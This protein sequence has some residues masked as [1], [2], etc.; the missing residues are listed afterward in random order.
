MSETVVLAYSGGLDTSVAVRWLAENRGFEVVTLTVDLGSQPNLQL[1]E[2]KALAS[3]ARRAVVADL[4]QEFVERYCWSALRAGALYQGR[5]PLATAL[6]RPL[7]A[8]RLVELAHLEG[9]AWVAHGST[10]KGNDQV[11]FEVAIRAL[12]PELQVT[13]PMREGMSMTRE[14]EIIYAQEHGIP[15]PVTLGSPY[16]IDENLWGRSV[17]AGALEDPTVEPPVDAF[18][19]TR[20]VADTPTDPEYLEISF[21]QG[22]P[23][24]LDGGPADS[25]AIVDSLNQR[26][27]A[28]GVGRIDMIENRFI[29]I[30][31]R[32]IYEAPAATVL[33]LAH[34]ALEDLVLD[35]E[36]AQFNELVSHEYAR[37]VYQGKWYSAQRRHLDAYVASSQRL[38]G[39][40]V[41]VKLHRGTAQVVGRTSPSSLYRPSL[42]TYSEGDQFDHATARGFIEIVGLP[43][44]VQSAV[45]GVEP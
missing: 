36:T 6:G 21:E 12:D 24:S 39:G 19:W 18:A 42:A 20:Q 26:A 31:S 3:G 8:R 44:R 9:A 40:S 22:V 34:Q 4:R 32:E 28:H 33:H 15:V 38:V 35:S 45:Q 27:G 16:S 23:V 25:V 7:I 43:L 14:Q 1:I 11:R 10:A 17:E 13:A 29:G 5:Y 37:L 41:R 2:R 30:K